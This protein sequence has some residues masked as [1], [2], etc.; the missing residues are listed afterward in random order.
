MGFAPLTKTKDLS[1][2]CSRAG[3]WSCKILVISDTLH[4]ADHRNR[5]RENKDARGAREAAKRDIT[6]TMLLYLSEELFSSGV[7]MLWTQSPLL[8]PLKRG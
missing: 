2:E 8:I 6:D 7:E 1:G 5:L 4:R 3:N